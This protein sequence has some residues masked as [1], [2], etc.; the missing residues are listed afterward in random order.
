MASRVKL[1]NAATPGTVGPTIHIGVGM[2]PYTIEVQGG[3][4][5]GAGAGVNIEISA[6]G[7]NFHRAM[8]KIGGENTTEAEVAELVDLADKTIASIDYYVKY[9]RALAGGGMV[10]V[11]GVGA[12]VYLQMP[13]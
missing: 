8:G 9:I 6:D 10:I 5:A 12:T 1:L 4:T 7:T 2:P 13:R 11:P 3:F